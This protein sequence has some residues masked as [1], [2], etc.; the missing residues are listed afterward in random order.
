MVYIFGHSY[1]HLI[2]YTTVKKIQSALISVFYK[3]GLESIV[4]KLHAQGVTLYS[5]G[6]T[7]A[8]IEKL[9]IPVIPVEELTSY[10]SI[11]GGRVKTLHPK[12][13]GGILYQRNLESDVLQAKEYAIPAIDLVIVDLYPFE[14]TLAAGGS[15]EEIIEKIDI[16]GVSLIR[17]AAKNHQDVLIVS[18]KEDYKKLETILDEKNGSTDLSDRKFF[19]AKAFAVTS[20]YD[21][22]I[23]DYL[24]QEENIEA[25]RIS[26]KQ[27]TPLRYGEN[28]HQKAVFA[29]NLDAFFEKLNGKELSYNNILD[30]DAA[31]NIIREFQEQSTFAIIKHTNTCG[32]ATRPTVTEAY[33]AALAGDPVSAFGGILITNTKIDIS[34][35]QKIHELFFEVLIAPS[36][37]AD[38][39]ELLKQKKN[40]ILL[41][42]KL[43]TN[44]IKQV[45]T[46]LNGYL[47][48]DVDLSV[49]D[50]NQFKTVTEKAP[51]TE[52]LSDLA[53]AIKAV[54]H[55]KSNTIVFVRNKQLLAMGCGQTSRIDATKQAI[56]KATA[57]GFSLEGAVMAS[58]AFFPF[59]DCV[60]VAQ[61][62]GIKAVVQPGGSIN[63]K[64]SIDFCNE[65]NIAMVLSGVRHFKH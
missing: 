64:L 34:V 42:Q 7:Q 54:K 24:N 60:E 38:A 12:V 39:L 35:A 10:P 2:F 53:F 11:F 56:E 58:D 8:F 63:D 50:K 23:F 4:Q 13:F 17:A 37:D 51:T 1:H 41:R 19:A 40:R 55:L 29:G 5:T 47:V 25:V 18:D 49:E 21:S 9:N 15:H 3:D 22:K 43:F 16:G 65:K 62:A 26:E 20:H 27:T 59:P 28:P 46:A 30:V 61:I 14:E 45:R 44:P 6:G 57:M 32:L 31:V 33:D 52:E 36:F 48:Q